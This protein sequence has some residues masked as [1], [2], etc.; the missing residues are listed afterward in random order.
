MN[1]T[2]VRIEPEEVLLPG[3]A[4]DFKAP[5]TRRESSTGLYRQEKV[6][7]RSDHVDRI[8]AIKKDFL[9]RKA[10]WQPSMA[11]ADV[12]NASLAFILRYVDFAEL[13]SVEGLDSYITSRLERGLPGHGRRQP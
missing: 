7:L 3:F 8:Q 10:H 2:L 4:K 12:I 13:E 6:L 5:A 11:L 9:E 1:N